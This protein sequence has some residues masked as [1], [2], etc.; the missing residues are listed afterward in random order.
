VAGT[1]NHQRATQ[2]T[3]TTMSPTIVPRTAP[4]TVAPVPEPPPSGGPGGSFGV[5]SDGDI[6]SVS[7]TSDREELA[8]PLIERD[9]DLGRPSDA[10]YEVDSGAPVEIQ[11][12]A[13]PA[14]GSSVPALGA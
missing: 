3:A 8:N 12:S 11:V 10:V 14:L 5:A 2:I 6:G 4:A 7:T 13:L 9:E 1:E